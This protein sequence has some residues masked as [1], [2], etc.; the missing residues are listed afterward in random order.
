MC[1]DEVPI[2]RNTPPV[3]TYR[4]ISI[5]LPWTHSQTD[6]VEVIYEVILYV[7][8]GKAGGVAHSFLKTT[9]CREADFMLE[10]HRTHL[11]PVLEDASVV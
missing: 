6:L 8:A 7:A 5:V 10:L 3:P 11:R 2:R 4:L 9:V 1:S